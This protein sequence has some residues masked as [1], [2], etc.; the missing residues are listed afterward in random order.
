MTDFYH[1]INNLKQI[2]PK[3]KYLTFMQIGEGK[4][5]HF[6]FSK[7]QTENIPDLCTIKINNKL[8]FK[9]IES[10]IQIIYLYDIG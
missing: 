3:L 2:F 8:K 5:S 7:I 10:K 9:I 4:L 6:N 1:L